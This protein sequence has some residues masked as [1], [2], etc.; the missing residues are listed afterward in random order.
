MGGQFAATGV[1]LLLLLLGQ[2][3]AAEC[4]LEELEDD[5]SHSLVQQEAYL[6]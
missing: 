6:D 3:T 5:G 4:A 2:G 1:L